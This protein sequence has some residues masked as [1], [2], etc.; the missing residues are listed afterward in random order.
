M[1]FHEKL[2]EYLPS[3]RRYSHAVTGSASE[4][5]ALVAA[6]I[7]SL[8]ASPTPL[9]NGRL[10]H[11]ELYRSLN[12]LLPTHLESGLRADAGPMR[13]RVQGL[14]LQ[15]RQALLLVSVERMSAAETAHI[16]GISEVQVGDLIVE[17]TRMMTSSIPAPEILIVGEHESAT[18]ALRRM[19]DSLGYA[20][21]DV[22]HS[23]QDA[24]E[25]PNDRRPGLVLADL[26]GQ[27]AIQ[28]LA[29][30]AKSLE[31][32]LVYISSTPLQT[33]AHDLDNAL[34]V[35]KPVDADRVKETIDRAIL[36]TDSQRNGAAQTI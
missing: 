7:N 1:K 3:L 36:E 34:H 27:H 14:P 21:S 11:I 16:L 6:L 5:D 32:P 2:G 13:Q 33:L 30:F 18:D 4:G 20:I 15:H 35:R 28:R 10:M 22:A 12:A 8:I 31:A 23:L 26:P 17:A 29:T 19:M 24:L 9:Q 25:I